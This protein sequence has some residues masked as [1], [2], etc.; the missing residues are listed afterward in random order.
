MVPLVLIFVVKL[1]VPEEIVP[2]LVKLE[3]VTVDFN[4]VPVKAP[5]SAIIGIV[6]SVLPSKGTP[7]IFFVVTNFVA[8]AALPVIF[9]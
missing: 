2:T 7:L 1:I 3:A 5:A 6:I 4:V 9:I 8:V